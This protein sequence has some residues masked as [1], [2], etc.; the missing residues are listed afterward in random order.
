MGQ[1][2]EDTSSSLTPEQ[3]LA[4]EH[5]TEWLK[6]H[7][8][9]W[10]WLANYGVIVDEDTGEVVKG[11]TL[12]DK[13]REYLEAVVAGHNVITGKSRQVGVSWLLENYEYWILEFRDRRRI[14]LIHY[15]ETEMHTH[16]G[17]V[18]LIRD[19]QP[20]YIKRKPVVEGHNN[21]SDFALG[22]SDNYSI[23]GGKTATRG[24]GRGISAMLVHCEEFAF[25]ENAKPVFTALRATAGSATRQIIIVSTANGEGNH[26]HK[27][28]K[29]AVAGR[30]SFVPVFI[31][32]TADPK[33]DAVWLDKAKKD[34]GEDFPQEYPADPEEMFVSTGTKYWSGKALATLREA[35]ECIPAETRHGDT[36]RIFD[37]PQKGKL[38]VIGADVADG[39]GDA[40]CASVVEV[41]SGLQVAKISSH[42]WENDRLRDHRWLANQFAD[43]L[44]ELGRLYNWAW[45]GVERNNNGS[46]TL[47]TLIRTLGYPTDRIYHHEDW[48]LESGAD[49]IVKPGWLTSKKSRPVLL[50][51]LRRAT[52]LNDI[53][54]QD[55]LTYTQMA[56]FGHYKG[57]WQHP[58]EEHDDEIFALGIAQ[59][60]R[61]YIQGELRGGGELTVYRGNEKIAG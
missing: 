44:A 48:D 4:I 40:C 42:V 52:D 56:Q 43:H 49:K 15:K 27:L 55:G 16:V 17:R 36:W 34:F 14:A 47:S 1:V 39:G 25:W 8:D 2:A 22:A 20:D 23:I 28:W 33:R 12:W 11:I 30:N 32:W 3:L 35:Y 29:D 59:Q 19:H 6:C 60:V 18:K 5:D 38:Y 46:D 7:D 13:Q 9:F 58:P 61:K 24:S 10:Y 53:Q 50:G 54:I 31:P 26:Y 57:R 21:K 41:E 37:P 45:L 51:E